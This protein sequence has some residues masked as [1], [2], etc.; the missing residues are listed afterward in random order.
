MLEK[1]VI[2]GNGIAGITAI[3]SIRKA[4]KES[5]I[6]LF[7]KEKFYPYNR[8]RLSKGLL[9]SLE[10]DSQRN[11]YNKVFIKN[12]KVIGAIV[13]GNIKY[14]PILKTAIEKSIDLSGITLKDVSFN[15]LI[16]IIKVKN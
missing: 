9:S 16:E 10:E 14:S 2:V 13:I 5:E 3:K 11:I 6:H 4:D 7:G 12:N 8:V 15:D 1:I